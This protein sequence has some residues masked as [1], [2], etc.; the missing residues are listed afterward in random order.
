M[1]HVQESSSL[2]F[3][4]LDRHHSISVDLQLQGA[5][6]VQE[7]HGPVTEEEEEKNEEEAEEG[8]QLVPTHP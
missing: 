2:G 3:K 4:A 7:V 6:K 1:R 8:L 5:P